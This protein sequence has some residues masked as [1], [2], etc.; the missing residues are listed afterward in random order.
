M[1]SV[2]WV[3]LQV[4]GGGMKELSG[5]MLSFCICLVHLDYIGVYVG[6][7]SHIV[8]IKFVDFSFT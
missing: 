2:Q 5:M 6:Q 1:K 3:P 4:K 7:N 8:Y